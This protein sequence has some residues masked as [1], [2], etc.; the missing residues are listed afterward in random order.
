MRSL[1]KCGA[2]KGTHP[3]SHSLSAWL[4]HH[5]WHREP[6]TRPA[7]RTFFFRKLTMREVVVVDN[8]VQ[9]IR[10][11][12]VARFRGWGNE[13]TSRQSFQDPFS[14]SEARWAAQ[15]WRPTIS[16][17]TWRMVRNFFPR[18]D[19]PPPRHQ[20]RTRF[21]GRPQGVSS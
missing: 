2:P 9:Q 11:R 10:F 4:L 7:V 5:D 17:T 14:W 3:V 6:Q 1:S 18:T 12:P 19:E 16:D 21:R 8:G 20:G 15:N 13:A